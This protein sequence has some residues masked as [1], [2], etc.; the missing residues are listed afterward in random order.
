MN[1]TISR[2]YLFHIPGNI[3]VRFIIFSNFFSTK[4]FEFRYITKHPEVSL[5]NPGRFTGVNVGVLLLKLSKMRQNRAYNRY[6]TSN[7]IET[8]VNTYGLN[9]TNMGTKIL[10]IHYP[11]KSFNFPC[12]F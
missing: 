4:T 11:K 10:K 7:G 5:S 9:R 2:N 6:L 1:C 3:W 8:L 12:F